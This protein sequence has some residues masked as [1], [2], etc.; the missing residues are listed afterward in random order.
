MSPLVTGF[1]GAKNEGTENSSSAAASSGSCTF[2]AQSSQPGTLSGSGSANH[3]GSNN[4]AARGSIKR[5]SLPCKE[6]E[7][8]LTEQDSIQPSDVAY[9]YTSMEAW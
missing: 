6:Y 4:S 7:P 2:E 8:L 9:D 5:P 3:P 1:D